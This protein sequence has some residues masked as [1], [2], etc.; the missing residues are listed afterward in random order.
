V[1]DT[2][3]HLVYGAVGLCVLLAMMMGFVRY[4]NSGWQWFALSFLAGSTFIAASV[5]AEHW[6]DWNRGGDSYMSLLAYL[7]PALAI[8]P[9]TLA[10]LI[11][12]FTSLR[13]SRQIA[14]GE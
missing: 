1:T 3:L 8:A 13:K 7:V 9:F 11:L 4:A 10:S 2:I 6:V 12:T 5:F 14:A